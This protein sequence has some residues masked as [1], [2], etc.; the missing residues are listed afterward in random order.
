MYIRTSSNLTF[1]NR[2][3]HWSLF[4]IY[5]YLCSIILLNTALALTLSLLISSSYKIFSC[6]GWLT[7]NLSNLTDY[8]KSLFLMQFDIWS[9][10]YF[11]KL[12]LINNFRQLCMSPF[13]NSFIISS[14]SNVFHFGTLI[15]SESL[16]NRNDY[17]IWR[18]QC[19][20]IVL[21]LYKA[22][23]LIFILALIKLYF[24]KTLRMT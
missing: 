14:S 20:A 19:S 7:R 5:L 9:L 8:L 18:S 12:Y 21:V 17:T 4:K 1:Q 23:K 15:W 10:T 2:S 22:E 13:V 11:C 3:K 6:T 24:V 16:R